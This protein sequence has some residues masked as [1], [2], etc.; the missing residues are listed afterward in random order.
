MRDELLALY[1]STSEYSDNFAK[2]TIKILKSYLLESGVSDDANIDGI[3][4]SNSNGS[5]FQSMLHFNIK[6]HDYLKGDRPV[7]FFKL[8]K[9]KEIIQTDTGDDINSTEI[10]D[11]TKMYLMLRGDA[12]MNQEELI[13]KYK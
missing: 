13:K 9:I 7:D 12:Q 5:L 2:E 11:W 1:K 10:V 8:A 3:A 4:D 6:L